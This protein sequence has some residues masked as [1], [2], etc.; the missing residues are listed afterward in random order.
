M[1]YNL[2][3]DSKLGYSELTGSMF[4]SAH[5]IGSN[6]DHEGAKLSEDDLDLS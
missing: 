4:P 5:A 2:G 6:P 1:F 3:Q